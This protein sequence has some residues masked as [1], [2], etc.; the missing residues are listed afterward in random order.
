MSAITPL[1]E[2]ASQLEEEV[3]GLSLTPALRD[4]ATLEREIEERLLILARQREVPDD[5]RLFVDGL[6]DELGLLPESTALR[7]DPYLLVAAQR[8]MILSLR[9]LDSDDEAWARRQIR[10]RLEQIRQVYRDLAEG[11]PTYE[12]RSAKQIASWLAEV[13]DV[14]Q[15]RLAELLGVSARTFQRWVSGSDPIGPEGDDARRVR[16]AA[17]VVNHLRHVLTGPGVVRW[18]ELPHPDL[19]GRRP[20]DLLDDRDAATRLATV[21][22]S[23]RSSTAA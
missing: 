20:L 5:I 13:L 15:A 7:V 3:P 12:D 1:V 16:I 9:A 8:A 22:A 14:S 19:D 4:P 23:A 11:G 2:D 10:V 17:R 21:A 6:A 18:F